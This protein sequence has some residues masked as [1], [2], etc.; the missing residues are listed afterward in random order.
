MDLR[1]AIEH[2]GLKMA[3]IARIW[4]VPVQNIAQL[5]KSKNPGYTTLKRLADTMKISVT[6]LVALAEGNNF[7]SVICPKCG[8]KLKVEINA[9]EEESQEEETK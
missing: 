4:N 1:K 5:C 6:E 7:T 8:A 3:D 9:E 2:N